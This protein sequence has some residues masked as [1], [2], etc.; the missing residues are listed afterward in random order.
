MGQRTLGPRHS[1]IFP[2]GYKKPVKPTLDVTHPLSRGLVGCFL[3]GDVPGKIV[4]I[5]P[6]QNDGSYTGSPTIATAHHGGLATHFS[7]TNYGLVPPGKQLDLGK[8]MT[9]MC[10][11]RVTGGS[12]VRCMVAKQNASDARNYYLATNS[13]SYR[14]YFTV[15]GAYKG[16]D[17]TTAYGTGWNH[18]AGTYDGATIRLYI[19]GKQDS[20]VAETGTPQTTT[21]DL[22]LGV[23]TTAPAE[24]Y[25]GDIDC[26]RIYNR[27]LS[28]NEIQRLYVE[29]YAGIYSADIPYRVAAS[30][31]GNVTVALTGVA[32][33]GSV[34]SV[35]VS[36]ENPLSGTN[37]TG[38][39]G[40]VTPTQGLSGV[41]G[42][43][44]VGTVGVNFDIP[45]TG[46]AGTGQ[47][48]SVTYSANSDVTVALSGV[49][50]TGQVGSVSPAFTLSPS[51]VSG[52][53]Q[54]GDVAPSQGL[55]GVQATGA[56]GS[57][58][59]AFSIPLTGVQGTGQVGTVTPS[60]TGDLTFAITGVAA[61]GQVGSVSV[62]SDAL[63][64]HDPGISPSEL[65]RLRKRLREQEQERQEEFARTV[66]KRAARRAQI[67]D[68]FETIVEGKPEIPEVI[69]NAIVEQIEN[70]EAQQPDKFDFQELVRSAE[71]LQALLDEYIE[72]DDEEV[73]MLL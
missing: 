7:G 31:G 16:L 69:A 67:I 12:G 13:T 70:K 57:V 43:G 1:L 24:G 62:P 51:G 23:L 25:P 30:G 26:V 11:S 19:N 45:L 8:Y 3:L 49:F 32:G 59:V 38:Q 58:S 52:T 46:V 63:D 65:K 4:D 50:G 47:V 56:V 27:T 41:S 54:V 2:S 6:F 22:R 72:R 14:F 42:T 61:T 10:W 35:G 15:A 18:V 40:S 28:A 71:K 29:P 39:V 66:E 73:L 48:G 33:T 17:G 68:A 21:T 5:S 9:V 53:G 44:Q 34:G 64:G 36:H 37:G 55:S 20:S 60:I